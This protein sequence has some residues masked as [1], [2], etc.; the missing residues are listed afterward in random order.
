MVVCQENLGSPDQT[1][2]D[3]DPPELQ[4]YRAL[5]DTQASLRSSQTKC[6]WVVWHMA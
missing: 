5:L 4:G 2:E 1:F 6:P 3:L